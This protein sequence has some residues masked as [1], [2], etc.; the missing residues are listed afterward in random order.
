M[1]I[2]MELQRVFNVKQYDW[3]GRRGKKSIGE[4]DIWHNH[5]RFS[6]FFFSLGVYSLQLITTFFMFRSLGY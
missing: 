1:V 4:W 6:G 2:S 3:F 5:Y